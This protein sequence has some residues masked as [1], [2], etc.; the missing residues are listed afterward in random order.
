M[1]DARCYAIFKNGKYV[2][3]TTSCEYT[4]DDITANWSVRA[5]NEMGGLGEAAEAVAITA[6]LSDGGMGTFCSATSCKAPEGLNIYTA[7]V[8]DNTVTLNKV[9]DGII[10]AGEG[11]VLGGEARTTYY[12]TPCEALEKLEGNSLKG[13]LERTLIENNNSFVLV[14][15]KTED[16]AYFK[17]FQNGAYIPA[18]KAYLD[19]PTAVQGAQLKVVINNGGTSGI[20]SFNADGN[21]NG[22]YFT[23]SGQKTMKP[24]RGLYIHNGKKI[25]IK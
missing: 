20:N 23:I 5:A 3:N 7:S 8:S 14:Y 18:G 13:T 17:N 19:I 21:D 1:N 12:M 25:I 16:V 10:P 24:Q 22:A 6:T 15:D 11:V 9:K 2:A 4:T